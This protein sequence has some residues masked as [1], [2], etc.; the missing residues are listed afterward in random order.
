MQNLIVPLFNGIRR[1]TKPLWISSCLLGNHV[2]YDG[3]HKSHQGVKSLALIFSH[4]AICP[5]LE[6]GLGVPRPSIAWYNN[7]LLENDSK[8]DHTSKAYSSA[9]SLVNTLEAPLGLIFKSKSPSCGLSDVAAKERGFFAETALT[10]YPDSPVVDENALSD[11]EATLAFALKLGA[12][13]KQLDDLQ[14]AWSFLA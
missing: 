2:R 11:I 7:R 1:V 5:E 4:Y 9:Q 10:T 14:K 3:G 8:L 13:H 6:M 12:S